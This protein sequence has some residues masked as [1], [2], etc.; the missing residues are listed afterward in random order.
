[1]GAFC[2]YVR[3][4]EDCHM[5]LLV[6]PVTIRTH[7]HVI[8]H[9]IEALQIRLNGYEVRLGRKTMSSIARDELTS[10]RDSIEMALL[11]LQDELATIDA[12]KVEG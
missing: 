3:W 8:E 7:R 12:A 2:P 4:Q 6:N 1:M 11:T 5:R 9:A 10:R